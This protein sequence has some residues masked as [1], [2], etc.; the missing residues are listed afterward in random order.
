M[1][2]KRV[3][4]LPDLVNRQSIGSKS[5]ETYKTRS[6]RTLIRRL[7]RTTVRHKVCLDVNGASERS[8]SA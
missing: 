8:A 4:E 3:V 6:L 7:D 1:D 2:M 5:Y